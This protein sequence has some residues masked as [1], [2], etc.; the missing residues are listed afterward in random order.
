MFFDALN[1]SIRGPEID[2]SPSL[3]HSSI[4]VAAFMSSVFNE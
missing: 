2:G 4:G 3:A 1:Y